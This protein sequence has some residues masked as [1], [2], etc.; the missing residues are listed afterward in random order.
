MAD[1]AVSILRDV[2][3]VVFFPHFEPLF[4]D[5][6]PEGLPVLV[7]FSHHIAVFDGELGPASL[8][9][10]LSDDWLEVVDWN[11]DV[12]GPSVKD[13]ISLLRQC[14]GGGA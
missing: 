2:N 12:S 13:G 11:E 10:H 4:L 5:H 3:Q 9:R 8:V 7:A 6:E 14:E 1:R